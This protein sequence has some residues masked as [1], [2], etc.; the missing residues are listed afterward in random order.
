MVKVAPVKM[1][2]ENGVSI[3]VEEKGKMSFWPKV[4]LINFI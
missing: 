1:K 4:C 3:E 2:E